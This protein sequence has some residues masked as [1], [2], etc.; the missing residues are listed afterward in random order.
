MI[1]LGELEQDALTEIFN[2]GV[3]L[4][5][6]ALYQMT[7]EHVPLSVPVVALASQRVALQH[8]AERDQVVYAIRQTYHG[9]FATDAVLMFAQTGSQ[10]LVRMMVGREL[11][12][13]QWAE[14]TEDALSELGNIILNAVMSELADALGLR[15]EG[16]LPTV[17]AVRANSLFADPEA[18]AGGAPETF[19]VLVL[20]IDFQLGAQQ[21]RGEMAFSLDTAS[22]ENLIA[23]LIHYAAGP[24][25]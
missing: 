4:A 16:S 11:P 19:Q 23:R 8:Y 18:G 12:P 6:D 9:A 10:S 14:V 13:Q 17:S 15:L 21:V 20:M 1:C 2:I 25:A 24:A 3:G 7:G 5:A 22:S